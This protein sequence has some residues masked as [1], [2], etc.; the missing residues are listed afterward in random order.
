MCL[1]GTKRRCRNFGARTILLHQAIGLIFNQIVYELNID[2]VDTKK[3]YQY[4]IGIHNLSN[5]LAKIA[6]FSLENF[7]TRVKKFK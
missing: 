1:V 2:N 7:L 4:K 5:S 3:V 6:V